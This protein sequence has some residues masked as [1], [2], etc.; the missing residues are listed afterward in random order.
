MVAV[1]QIFAK[2]LKGATV[3]IDVGSSDTYAAIA[4]RIEAKTGA[5]VLRLVVEGKEVAW[6]DLCTI[7]K[8]GTVHVLWRL[9]GGGTSSTADP[10]RQ[11][12]KNRNALCRPLSSDPL[13]I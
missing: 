5:A 8:E 1:Y 2:D 12:S 13:P 3:T 9:L 4:E 7:G 11:G 10:V 6:S